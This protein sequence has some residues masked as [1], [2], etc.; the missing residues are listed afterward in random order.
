MPQLQIKVNEI[1]IENMPLE[2]LKS[3]V[4]FVK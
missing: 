4:A 1:T 3:A 2:S